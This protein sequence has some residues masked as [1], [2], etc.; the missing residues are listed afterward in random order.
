MKHSTKSVLQPDA[1]DCA[2]GQER[3]RGA[4]KTCSHPSSSATL[5]VDLLEVLD[6]AC[7]AQ[8]KV[9]K[10]VNDHQNMAEQRIIG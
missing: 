8:V 2:S 7:P 4:S 10:E 3:N 5:I 9:E 6:C 1:P